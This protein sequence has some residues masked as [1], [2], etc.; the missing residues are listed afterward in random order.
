LTIDVTSYL[1]ALPVNDASAPAFFI[2][3]AAAADGTTIVFDSKESPGTSHAP[4]LE[5]VTGPL[6]AVVESDGTIARG[7]A[8]V[9]STRI[10]SGS[11]EVTFPKNVTGCAYMVTSA[12][13]GSAGL[14]PHAITGAVGRVN[15]PRAILVTTRDTS[16]TLIDR[17]FH[18][19]VVGP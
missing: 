9:T 13:S 7:S 3:Q 1:Q 4:E 14:P 18:V 8:G 5:I 2:E 17:P 10:S 11:Y 12:L 19:V 15:N 6:F 16:G